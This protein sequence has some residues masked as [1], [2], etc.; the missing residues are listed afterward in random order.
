MSAQN[1]NEKETGGAPMQ[2][3]STTGNGWSQFGSNTMGASSSGQPPPN[4]R[5]ESETP[6]TKKKKRQYKDFEHD[7][8]GPSRTPPL[9]L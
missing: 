6:S 1:G 9:F 3:Q 7:Q 8:E 4:I 5:V 2:S